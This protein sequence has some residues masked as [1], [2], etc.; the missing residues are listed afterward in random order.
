MKY[1]CKCKVCDK[2]FHYMDEQSP[3]FANE[4]WWDLLDYYGLWR[5][6]ARA[7]ILNMEAHYQWQQAGKPRNEFPIKDEY[8]CFICYEC[9]E[10]ALG[11]RLTLEDLHSECDNELFINHYFNK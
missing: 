11:R 5:Y 3:M 2:T 9:A 4:I 8:H 7:K 10:K 1:L 6:E